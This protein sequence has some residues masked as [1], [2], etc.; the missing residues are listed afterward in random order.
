MK[1]ARF[2]F[3][4]MTSLEHLFLS[5]DKFKRGKRKR[6]DIQYFE[7]HLED[8]IFQL[9]HDLVSFQYLHVPYEQFYVTDPK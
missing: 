3:E 8:N 1:I 6:K 5:W 4:K 9:H 7:K 2:L